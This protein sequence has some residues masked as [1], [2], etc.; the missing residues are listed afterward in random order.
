MEY[1][2]FT[3]SIE[4]SEDDNLFFGKVLGI[5]ALLS[6]EGSTLRDLEQAFHSV[7]DDYIAFSKSQAAD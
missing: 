4:F 2:N 5:R 7:V 3:G 6:Y 1:K